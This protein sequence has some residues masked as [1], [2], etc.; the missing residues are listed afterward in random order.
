MPQS[1]NEN[2]KI[3]HLQDSY[4]LDPEKQP[5]K[6]APLLLDPSAHQTVY[7]KNIHP[8]FK[9]TVVDIWREKPSI[10]NRAYFYCV[11]DRGGRKN[12]P[13][14]N[15]NK[16]KLVLMMKYSPFQGH[17][18]LVLWPSSSWFWIWVQFFLAFHYSMDVL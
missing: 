1:T 10:Y 2:L 11:R 17:N 15:W 13:K 16:C 4:A 6:S 12:P 8:R 7:R 5:A 14:R 9:T 3:Q 18:Q